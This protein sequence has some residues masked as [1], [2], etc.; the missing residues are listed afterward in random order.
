MLKTWLKGVS[1][2]KDDKRMMYA[3]HLHCFDNEN[4]IAVLVFSD[5]ANLQIKPKNHPSASC[6]LDISLRVLLTH[7]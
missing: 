7:L 4:K 1:Q 3:S 6:L 2:V 5:L